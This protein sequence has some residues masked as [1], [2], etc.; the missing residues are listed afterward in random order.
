MRNRLLEALPREL[1][2]YRAEGMVWFVVGA[3]DPQMQ[4]R[5]EQWLKAGKLAQ[6]AQFGGLRIYKISA[7]A[8]PVA[9]SG[10]PQL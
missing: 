7:G 9:G 4:Q 3:D 1:G 6:Q 10:L 2:Q 8:P 5:A